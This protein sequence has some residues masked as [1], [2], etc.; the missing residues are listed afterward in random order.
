MERDDLDSSIALVQGVAGDFFVPRDHP[1]F[2]EIRETGAVTRPE[3]AMLI[4]FVAPGMTVAD[5]G[6]SFGAFTIPL[7]RAAGPGGRVGALEE[8][9]LLGKLLGWNLVLNGLDR[10]SSPVH[11]GPWPRPQ[12]W[13]AE[14]GVGEVD[15]IRL[16]GLRATTEFVAD[17]APLIAASR[18]LVFITMASEMEPPVADPL[19]ETLLGAGY[20]FFRHSG[21]A[22]D[23]GDGFKLDAV[24]RFARTSGGFS[25][26]ALP[27]DSGAA[28][29]AHKTAGAQG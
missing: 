25:V 11:C 10:F 7:Q 3:L 29:R 17:L 23:T 22:H 27:D 19:E 16:D 5:V 26:L 13:A 14:A 28:K 12:T 8:N 15:L 1:G 6:A 21:G 18:P 9:E 20:D 4:D 2:D 24:R